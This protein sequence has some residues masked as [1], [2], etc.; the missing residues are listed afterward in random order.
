M[1]L[2]NMCIK[3]LSYFCALP[4]PKNEREET[5]SYTASGFIDHFS[6]P[7]ESGYKIIKNLEKSGL[8]RRSSLHNFGPRGRPQVIYVATKKGREYLCAVGDFK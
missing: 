7:K 2:R 3:A 1:N 5:R 4:T 6:L 8:I